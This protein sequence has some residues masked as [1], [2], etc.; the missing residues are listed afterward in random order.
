MAST[1]D[2]L[3]RGARCGDRPARDIRPPARRAGAADWA[4]AIELVNGV[5]Q[6]LVAALFSSSPTTVTRFLE[7]AQAGI[8]KIN[9]STADADVDVPFGGWRHSG[10]GPP[11]HGPFDRDFYTRPQ[12]VYR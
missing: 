1:D 5:E 4:Q 3:L 6:G 8:L 11:E 2:R 7:E 12:V 10:V 9:S